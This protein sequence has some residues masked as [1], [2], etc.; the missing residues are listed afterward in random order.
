M[1]L[2]YLILFLFIST[3]NCCEQIFTVKNL[4]VTEYIRKEWYIQKQQV[5]PYLPKNENYCVKA[6]YTLSNKK[7]PF[8]NGEVLNVY[9][10][11]NIDKVN[12]NNANKNNN[13]L[14]ARIPNSN[15]QSKLLVGPCFLPNLLAGDYWIIAVGPNSN[16]YQWAIIIGGQPTESYRDGCTTKT[17]SI[18]NSGLWIFTRDQNPSKTII[19]FL[20]RMINS[21][22]ISTLL[23]NDVVQLG[24]TYSS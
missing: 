22:G 3:S 19:N 18:N 10:Y 7:V 12:G 23:L 17:N 11:A 5:T 21:K 15:L 8:F 20:L 6:K 2:I 13:T 1:K 9:N 24:C 16:N 4:N 14:C